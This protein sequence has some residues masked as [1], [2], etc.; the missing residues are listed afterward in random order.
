MPLQRLVSVAELP[1]GRTKTFIYKD[2]DG[3]KRDGFVA[4]FDGRF[5]AYENRCRHLPLTLDY[6]D[7]RFFT[8][9]G[10]H[11]I[12]QTHGA[13]YEPLTGLCIRGPCPG[14]SLQPL[15]IKVRDDAVWLVPPRAESLPASSV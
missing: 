11:F 15:A 10:R 3:I 4:N 2:A 13:T 14:A 6:A 5:V 12:C 7:N 8:T 1:P 9:D